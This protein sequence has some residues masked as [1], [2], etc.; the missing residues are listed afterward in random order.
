MKIFV[1][2]FCS[3]GLLYFFIRVT[4]RQVTALKLC[5]TVVVL[6]V[7]GKLTCGS[8]FCNVGD[9]QTQI[10]MELSHT[11]ELYLKRLGG[12]SCKSQLFKVTN[13]E[14]P[15]WMFSLACN[16]L[17]MDACSNDFEKI[18]LAKN[19]CDYNQMRSNQIAANINALN[20]FH[21]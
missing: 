2:L 19:L 10:S 7:H 12:Q 4:S 16:F 21:F 3:S 14:N 17:K 8:S 20:H 5:G 6:E 18:F 13:K 11:R 1:S 15:L 9:C